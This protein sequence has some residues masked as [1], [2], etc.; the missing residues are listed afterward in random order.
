[1]NTLASVAGK[2]S[3]DIESKVVKKIMLR[4]LPFLMLGYFIAFMD[5]VN[6]GFAA[7]LC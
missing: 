7:G 3:D 6:I 5:R 1:M 4:I 2:R